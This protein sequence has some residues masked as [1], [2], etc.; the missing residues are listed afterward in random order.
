M[1]PFPVKGVVS[2]ERF[3]EI[4]FLLNIT[5]VPSSW[6]IPVYIPTSSVCMSV[7]VSS[8]PN[9]QNVLSF[10]L[11]LPSRRSVMNTQIF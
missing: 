3:L 5:G 10:F 2:L 6:S 9:E 8:Q 11:Y 7:P 1:L 4:E